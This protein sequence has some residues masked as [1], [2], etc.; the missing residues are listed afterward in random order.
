MR[1]GLVVFPMSDTYLAQA[2]QIGV[3]DV[4][5]YD[6]T[7]MP[8]NPEAILAVKDRV[9]QFGL[10]MSVV[11]GGPPTT[12]IILHKDGRDE[13]IENWKR[14]LDAMGGAGVRVLCYDW[15]P[16][17]QGVIRTSFDYPSRGGALVSS[18]RLADYDNNTLT[19][20]GETTDEQM[21]DD[22]AYF[23]K[24]VIPAAEAA[25]VKLAMHP[26]DPPMSPLKGLARIMRSPEAFDRLFE[27]EPSECNGMTFC[28]GCFAEMGTD[29]PAMIRHF[30][31][32]IQFAHFRDVQGDVEDFYET[33][34]DEGK[35]DMLEAIRT[36]RDIGFEGVVRPDHV[37]LLE[38]VDRTE[39]DEGYTM[40]GRLH[41]VGYM[42]ALKQVADRD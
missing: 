31:D 23:L 6:M 1:I 12:Q 3:Q 14:C 25:G 11:E 9:D 2:A 40:T 10:T 21:W 22:L 17:N 16:P 20:E 4:V 28:Q 15:M 13:Q 35:T 38:G 7:Q 39:A 42:K 19:E 27:M 41:A 32:R 24:R 30:K 37:P 18:F 5:Y 34:H 29:V 26:D 36:Y 8:D 33:F